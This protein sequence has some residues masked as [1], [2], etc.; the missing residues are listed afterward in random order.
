MEATTPRG[1]Y[2]LA[3]E[4]AGPVRRTKPSPTPGWLFDAAVVA[5]LV[6]T[7]VGSLTA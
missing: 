3:Y 6:I 7:A 2:A 5:L 1:L 4:T